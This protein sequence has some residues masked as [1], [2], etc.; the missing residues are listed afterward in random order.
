MITTQPKYTK[1]LDNFT[2]DE[3]GA[4]IGLKTTFDNGDIEE[5]ILYEMRTNGR[6]ITCYVQEFLTVG[7]TN[8]RICTPSGRYQHGMFVADDNSWIS[9][10]TGKVY[11]QKPVNITYRLSTGEVVDIEP[12]SDVEFI[13]IT[14]P[15][16][17][18]ITQ[19]EYFHSVLGLQIEGF[20]LAEMTK[21]VK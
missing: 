20:Q 8:Q 16:D 17:G 21:R 1:V 11:T 12:T 3:H 6:T 4:Y 15:K 10:T 5:T 13:I 9:L 2:E 7:R 19:F 14:T 18:Y